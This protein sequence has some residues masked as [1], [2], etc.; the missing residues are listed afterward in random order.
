MVVRSRLHHRQRVHLL[1]RP[2]VRA[3]DRRHARRHLHRAIKAAGVDA[4]LGELG[5]V[6]EEVINSYE[7]TIDGAR[8]PVAAARDTEA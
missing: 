1:V 5:G 8:T 4:N 3:A 6:I 7:V 2:A